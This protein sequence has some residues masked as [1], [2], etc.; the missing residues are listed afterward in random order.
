MIG[1]VQKK[2]VEEIEI[3]ITAEDIMKKIFIRCALGIALLISFSVSNVTAQ[4]DEA[5]LEELAQK[6]IHT[7]AIV[8]PGDVVV[9]SGA[10]HTIPLME[11]LAIEAQKAGG[12]VTL[13]LDSDKVI[14][15]YYADVDE[16]YLGQ[17]PVYFAEWLKQMDV[18]IQLPWTKDPKAVYSDIPAE[19]YEKASKADEY[20]QSKIGEIGVRLVNIGYPNKKR[21]EIYK[22]DYDVYESMHW[23]AIKTDYSRISEIGAKFESLLRDSKTV[24]ITSPDG[25]DFTFTIG[26]RPIFVND[27]IVTEEEAHSELLLKRFAT[28]PAGS[29][30]FAP[31][32]KSVNGKVIIPKTDCNFEPLENVSFELKNGKMINLNAS[33]GLDCL[34][35]L[36]APYKGPKDIFGSVM[37]GLNPELKPAINGSD[38]YPA[39]A[40]G[41]VYISIGNNIYQGGNNNTR[42]YLSFPLVNATV[43]VDGKAIVKDGALVF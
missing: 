20:I 5:T 25:V 10:A 30:T 11:L 14:R 18:F 39:E 42:S 28:L 6:V 38:Y 35:D 43:L 19:R 26:E 36:L 41:L 34:N 7:S 27:G 33:T 12:M 15:S 1:T 31:L 13:F 3:K 24:R 32:E 9:I 37:I 29:I 23:Q 4:V 17:E 40:A 22:L 2:E 16:K 21:A 8:K